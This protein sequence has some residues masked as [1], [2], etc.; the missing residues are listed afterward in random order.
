MFIQQEISCM[1][2]DDF[3]NLPYEPIIGKI[4]KPL[5]K[6]YERQTDCFYLTH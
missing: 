2:V 4:V 6:A 1:F 3:C 5:S